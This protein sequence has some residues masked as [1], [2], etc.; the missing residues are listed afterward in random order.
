MKLKTTLTNIVAGMA[1]SLS[2]V[3]YASNSH[4]EVWAVDQAF[5]GGN[6]VDAGM[7][8][9]YKGTDRKFKGEYGGP[10][11]IHTSVMADD[12][13]AGGWDIG[14]KPHMTLFT[15]SGSHMVIG[16]ASNGVI[17][18]I[19]AESK[20]IVDTYN[21]RTDVSD[22][23]G[24]FDGIGKTHAVIP[25]PDNTF[26]IVADTDVAPSIIKISLDLSG[27]CA[28][29][30]GRPN[31][32]QYFDCDA[33]STSAAIEIQ[34]SPGNS[35][36]PVI[37]DDS[38]YAY[39]TLAGGGLDI[40]DLTFNAV[41]YSYTADSAMTA[42]TGSTTRGEIGP[43]GCGGIQNGD[44]V[45]VNS[46]NP[47]P[48]HTDVVYAFDNSVLPYNKPTF[49]RIPQSGNDS[50]GMLIA[51]HYVW[52]CNRGDN[53]CNVIDSVTHRVVNVI[54]LEAGGRLG[55][56][57][58]DLIDLSPSGKVVFIAQRGPVPVSANNPNFDN[59]KGDKPGVG[60]LAVKKG[61]KDGR[62][63]NHLP[64]TNNIDGTNFAD[65]H[66]IRVRK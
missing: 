42:V 10:Q 2:G 65:I 55:D 60:V 6:N 61:G 36:C 1:I 4:Y 52:A 34:H 45:F 28:G 57:A 17:Y 25:S 19:D 5:D 8:Y 39:V 46:G 62:A 49:T 23:G 32:H 33:G 35:I 27:S 41:I 14:K 50:H 58:P 48:E 43:N 7:L 16:H 3:T 11:L 13:A 47:D 24:T 64:I 38:K 59:A 56:V 18:L 20:T 53:T 12:A 66:A 44:T 29:T 51:G 31:R 15:G 9:V 30:G 37:T 21:I 63:K 40:V 54:D 22:P 26:V